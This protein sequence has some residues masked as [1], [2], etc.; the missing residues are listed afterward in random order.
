MRRL[1]IALAFAVA[2]ACTPPAAETPA[3]PEAPPAETVD[4]GPYSNSWESAEFS[5]FEHVLHAPGP[6]AHTLTLSAQTNSPGGETV[7]V[8]PVGPDGLPSTARIMFV[9]ATT[10]GNSETA[11]LVFP[12]DGAGAPVVVV[13]ENASGRVLSGSYTLSVG[14]AAAPTP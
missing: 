11:E 10:V 7:A 13:V 12:P 1:I 3:A 4:L 5:R 6:G 2:G 9:V 8:Y 14:P